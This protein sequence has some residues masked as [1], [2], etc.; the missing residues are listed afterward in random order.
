MLEGKWSIARL[1]Q[2]HVVRKLSFYVKYALDLSNYFAF[3]RCRAAKAETT[4]GMTEAEQLIL[5]ATRLV[6]CR[7]PDEPIPV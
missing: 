7:S 4:C 6:N 5:K 3:M 2:L 1:F